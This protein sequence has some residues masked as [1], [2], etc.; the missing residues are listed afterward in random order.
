MIQE[1]AKPWIRILI[2]FQV[3]GFWFANKETVKAFL[4]VLVIG[5]LQKPRTH[6]LDKVGNIPQAAHDQLFLFSASSTKQT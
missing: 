1:I 5:S 2:C 4:E 3:L 6:I